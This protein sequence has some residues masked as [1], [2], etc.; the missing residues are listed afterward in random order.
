MFYFI[1]FVY[2]FVFLWSAMPFSCL[3]LLFVGDHL[4]PS[5]FV[6]GVVGCDTVVDSLIIVRGLLLYPILFC[7]FVCFLWSSMPS[8]LTQYTL[9]HEHS[10]FSA[11][12]RCSK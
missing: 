1:L 6:D 9:S 11:N 7:L 2:L 10:G 12:N 3:C 5:C 4:L 8:F